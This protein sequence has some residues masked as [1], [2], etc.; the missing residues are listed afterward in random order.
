MYRE[1]IMKKK[2]KQISLG[3]KTARDSKYTGRRRP[4]PFQLFCVFELFD[5]NKQ[6]KRLIP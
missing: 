1:W 5:K 2:E 3:K 6:M 4:T